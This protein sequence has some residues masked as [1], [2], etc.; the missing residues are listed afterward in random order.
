MENKKI[1]VFGEQ[2][3]ILFGFQLVFYY[4]LKINGVF[5]NFFL[6]WVLYLGWYGFGVIS[7]FAGF[8]TGIIYD[9]IVKGTLGWSS[10]LLLIV[11][12][13]NNLFPGKTYLKR[14]LNALFFSLFYFIFLV[15]A[16]AYGFLWSKWAVLR[17]SF[18]FGMYNVFIVSVIEWYTRRLKWKK[19]KF[20][21]I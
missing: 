14:V 15:F 17:F 8:F 1:I 11:A 10:I 2:F 18:T 16:P 20:L 21:E 7:L 4:F 6:I 3:F 5:P 13:F 19:K 12:Y 9:C